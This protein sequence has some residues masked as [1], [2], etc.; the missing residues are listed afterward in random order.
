MHTQGQFQDL[1]SQ[2]DLSG[3]SVPPLL[4]PLSPKTNQGSNRAC[5]KKRK[6]TQNA[7]G[8]I[9]SGDQQTNKARTET[10]C[11][12]NDNPTLLADRTGYK[13]NNTSL[14]AAHT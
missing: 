1:R 10:A 2:V 7:K 4:S 3:L 6:Q 8:N 14:V 13:A 5:S 11:D 9:Q 12:A